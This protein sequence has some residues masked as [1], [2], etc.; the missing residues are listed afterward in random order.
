MIKIHSILCGN[1]MMK[2]LTETLGK[3]M[4]E[5]FKRLKKYAK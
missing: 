3:G 5:Y 2:P 4:E 1:V